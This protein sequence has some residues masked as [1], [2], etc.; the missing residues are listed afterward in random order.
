MA[1]APAPNPIPPG[2]AV[3]RVPGTQVP[4]EQ[5]IPGNL[6]QSI[7]ARKYWSSTGMV[8]SFNPHRRIPLGLDPSIHGPSYLFISRPD[9]N[10]G[11][12]SGAN[13]R[14]LPWN[15]HPDCAEYHL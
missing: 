5:N 12:G 15:W 11:G 7:K 3:P 1:T 8:T 6:L 13:T 4:D 9:L 14:K 2:Q 10:I